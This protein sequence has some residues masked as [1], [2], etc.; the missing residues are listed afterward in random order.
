M[1]RSVTKSPSHQGHVAPAEECSLIRLQQ[2][3]G[4]HILWGQLSHQLSILKELKSQEKKDS[5]AGLT[6]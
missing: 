5:E 6:K 2:Q 4:Y 1:M 3:S